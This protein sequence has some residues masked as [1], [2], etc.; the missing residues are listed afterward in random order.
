MMELSLLGPLRTSAARDPF[1]RSG[2]VLQSADL[3][4]IGMYKRNIAEGATLKRSLLTGSG[5]VT[6]C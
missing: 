2:S 5:P 3:K 4:T 6:L 1:Q